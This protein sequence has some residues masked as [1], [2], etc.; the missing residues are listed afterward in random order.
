VHDNIHV[1]FSPQ[2]GNVTVSAGEDGSFLIDDNLSERSLAIYEATQKIAQQDIKFILNTHY[3]YDH[4]GNNEFFGTRDAIILAHDNV[5]KRLSTDQFI[6][7]FEKEMPATKQIGLP[8]VTFA[9]TMTLHY[10]SH[11][12]NFIHTPAAHT[13]GD[14]V[15]H[16]TQSN[17]I[18]GGDLLFN[19]MYPFID[20]EHGGSIKGLINGLD[21]LLN[22]ADKKTVIIPGHGVLMT[23]DDLQTYRDTLADITQ[24]IEKLIK[25]KKT[26]NDVITAKPTTSY[27]ERLGGGF[28]SPEAIVTVIYN[29]LK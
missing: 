27:D 25:E 28:I 6:T 16:F 20:T 4:T 23:K 13:D 1:L 10:N 19:G 3:H 17:V 7:F 5:R 2:G 24:T 12:I 8:T 29:S 11:D 15:V 21:V 14:V 26:L 22:L 9:D 18:V